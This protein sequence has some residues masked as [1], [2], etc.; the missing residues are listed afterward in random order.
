MIDSL[1]D[2]T[3]SSRNHNSISEFH[4]NEYL[5]SCIV[6]RFWCVTTTT[7][8]CFQAFIFSTNSIFSEQINKL[9][10]QA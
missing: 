1:Q 4:P 8:N 5:G 9:Q 2:E 10:N 6:F 3:N 7:K